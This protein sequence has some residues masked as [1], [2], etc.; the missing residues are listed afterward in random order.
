MTAILAKLAQQVIQQVSP[1]LKK[2]IC[3]SI[4]T[5]EAK[6]K[7][8]PSPWDDIVVELLKALFSCP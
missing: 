6:A 3:E 5:W 2:L 1:E 7:E 4:N 8:T